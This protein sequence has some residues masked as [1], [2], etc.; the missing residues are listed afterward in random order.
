MKT[1]AAADLYMQL[2][3]MAAVRDIADFPAKIRDAAGRSTL[4]VRPLFASEGA[5]PG[6]EF[7]ISYSGISW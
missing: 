6:T 1:K 5:M 3:F 2:Y 4:G 7:I